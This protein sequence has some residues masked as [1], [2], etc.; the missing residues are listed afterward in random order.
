MKH[1]KAYSK[2]NLGA[3]T[4]AF[5]VDVFNALNRKF[6]NFVENVGMTKDRILTAIAKAAFYYHRGYSRARDKAK[7]LRDMIAKDMNATEIERSAILRLLLMLEEIK[8][9]EY[10]L[11]DTYLSAQKIGASTIAESIGA[12]TKQAAAATGDHLKQ[13]AKETVQD[14]FALIKSGVNV[15][16]EAAPW[17]LKPKVL[18]PVGLGLLFLVYGLPLLKTA[19]SFRPNYQSNP[20][21]AAR[22]KARKKYEEFHAAKPKKTISLPKIDTDELVELGKAIE[23]GYKSKKWEGKYNNYLHQFGKNVRLCATADGKALV[24]V[25]GKLATTDRGIVG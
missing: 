25:G 15:V 23:I 12:S 20:I 2:T 8:R 21:P 16:N 22:V 14:S 11:L 6:S 4:V 10:P 17:Y 19:K 5:H 3:L 9:P 18:L 1:S 7:S 13:V 24:I